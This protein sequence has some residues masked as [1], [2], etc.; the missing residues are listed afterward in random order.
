MT[1][2]QVEAEKASELARA[3][4]AQEDLKRQSVEIDQQK[5]DIAKK[6]LGSQMFADIAS[7]VSGFIHG[8]NPTG[9]ISM[10]R[11]KPTTTYVAPFSKGSPFQAAPFRSLK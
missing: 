7:G 6:R 2:L 9:F 5:A 11:R 4:R 3:N 10:L 8:L 1:T